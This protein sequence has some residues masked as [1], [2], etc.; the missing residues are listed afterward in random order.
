MDKDISGNNVCPKRIMK[1][2]S[3][4]WG[5]AYSKALLSPFSSVSLRHLAE[6]RKAGDDAGRKAGGQPGRRAS[7]VTLRSQADTEPLKHV[8][9]R[10]HVARL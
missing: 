9:R 1:C 6:W 5:T 3:D 4:A 8:K 10:C 2:C 7:R